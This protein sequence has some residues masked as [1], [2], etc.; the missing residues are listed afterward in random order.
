MAVMAD[1]WV[2]EADRCTHVH[3]GP[4]QDLPGSET[5]TLDVRSGL[6]SIRQLV[7]LQL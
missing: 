6:W 4:C 7:K 5:E 1:A 3:Y 2:P